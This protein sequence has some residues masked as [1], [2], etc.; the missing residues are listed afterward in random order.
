MDHTGTSFLL[1]ISG[2][3]G[4]GKSSVYQPLMR[5][6]PSLRFSV[7]C[8]TRAPRKGELDGEHYHFLSREAFEKQQAAGAFAENFTVHGQLYGTRR[9]DLDAMLDEGLVPVL[10]VDVQGGERLLAAYGERVVSVF[11][12][13]PSWE[14]LERRLRERGTEDPE[15]LRLRLENARW[16]VG[17]ARHYGYWIVNE[18]LDRSIADLEAVLRAERLRRV[19]W[20]QTPLSGPAE[21][22]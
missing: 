22:S 8:T 14:E 12:F 16:E 15:E 1:L 21:A 19:H 10:D 20:P 3:S 11:I 6:D 2:P 18:E 4:A 9:A 13:P 17:Y 7:S 5:R